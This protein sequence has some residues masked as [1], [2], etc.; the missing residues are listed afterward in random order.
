M[1]NKLHLSEHIDIWI[2]WLE[3]DRIQYKNHTGMPSA[4]ASDL[5]CGIAIHELKKCRDTNDEWTVK[6]IRNFAVAR[7]KREMESTKEYSYLRETDPNK[8]FWK[9]YDQAFLEQADT[10]INYLEGLIKDYQ[11]LAACPE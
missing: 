10:I 5:V 9:Q 7:L 4:D 3:Y 11:T 1:K 6:Y 8:T 2:A